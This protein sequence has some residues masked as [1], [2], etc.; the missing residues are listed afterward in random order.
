MAVYFLYLPVS[1]RCLW[2]NQ[3]SKFQLPISTYGDPSNLE[4][5]FS[6]APLIP[7]DL[8]LALSLNWITIE[9]M[10]DEMSYI[11][12]TIK[13]CLKLVK[14]VKETDNGNDKEGL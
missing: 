4:T 12:D 9:E 13:A 7:V 8:H 11:N 6:D 1:N 3:L 2:S 5:T 10:A 14:D